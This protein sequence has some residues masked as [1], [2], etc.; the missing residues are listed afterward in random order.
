MRQ[1]KRQVSPLQTFSQHQTSYPIRTEN[2]D[3]SSPIPENT[4]QPILSMLYHCIYN[5]LIA[6]NI[7]NPPHTHTYRVLLET[8]Y[9]SSLP[10]DFTV[11]I[12]L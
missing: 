6:R 12:L 1:R 8:F 10:Q 9:K 4:P 2:Q 5:L 11:K 7:G 3:T